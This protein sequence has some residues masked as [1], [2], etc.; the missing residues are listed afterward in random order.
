MGAYLPFPETALEQQIAKVRDLR[1]ELESRTQELHELQVAFNQQHSALIEA[2][3]KAA[4]DC[5]QEEQQLRELT[6]QAYEETGSKKPAEGVGIRI[7]KKLQYDENSIKH[8]A[9]QE[10]HIMF[11]SLDRAGFE[12]WAKAMMKS[13]MLPESLHESGAAV[14]EI[15]SPQ[16]TIAREL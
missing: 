3:C 14:N 2:K 1:V 5:A 7:T 12:G 13:S 8:W 10:G 4:S 16:A 9:I 6:L 15:E 11:L